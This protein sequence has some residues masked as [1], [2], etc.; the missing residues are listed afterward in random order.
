MTDVSIS[1][2]SCEVGGV[3]FVLRADNEAMARVELALNLSFAIPFH[4]SIT[5]GPPRMVDVSELFA[6]LTL[7]KKDGRRYTGVD[8]RRIMPFDGGETMTAVANHIA[9]A[10]AKGMP[11]AKPADQTTEGGGGN[12]VDPSI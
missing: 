7:P 9:T 8:I 5:I 4:R 11:V 12:G 10:V 6:A 3:A 2:Y 1:D